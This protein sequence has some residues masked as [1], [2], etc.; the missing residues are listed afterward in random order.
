MLRICRVALIGCALVAAV[1][2]F[3]ASVVGKWMGHGEVSS[4]NAADP[5]TIMR[6][7]KM[8]RSMKLTLT[9]K[10]D[11]TFVATFSNA[12]TKSPMVQKG[13]W[14]QTGNKV[15]AKSTSNIEN[16]TM[17]ANGKTMVVDL[18]GQDGIKFVFV[19]SG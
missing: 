13:T 6:T 7:Q 5:S 15:A 12:E 2:S 17:S 1:P 11:K 16:L 14:T 4:N 3:A 19:R 9:F 8:L 10:A 18:I